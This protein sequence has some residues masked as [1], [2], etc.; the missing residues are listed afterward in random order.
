MKIVNESLEQVEG[1]K[2]PKNVKSETKIQ[3]LNR[4]AKDD[5]NINQISYSLGFEDIQT[6]SRFFKKMK[7]ISPSKYRK[8]K[9]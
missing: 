7:N 5:L 1:L 3:I 8:G 6:F 9:N 4:L 2:K